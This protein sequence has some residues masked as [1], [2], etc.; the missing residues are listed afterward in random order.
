MGRP[1][2]SKNVEKLKTFTGSAKE[3]AT[4]RMTTQHRFA[5]LSR[6]YTIEALETILGC[7]RQTE[8][9]RL[10]LEAAKTILERGWG[11]P[12]QEINVQGDAP[13]V[14]VSLTDD[15][16]MELAQAKLPAIEGE[17]EPV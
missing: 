16:L 2:G 11:K 7:M 14:L 5:A 1:K 10:R 8:D 3:F 4:H 9:R 6:S 13:V 12:K 17:C 15:Q